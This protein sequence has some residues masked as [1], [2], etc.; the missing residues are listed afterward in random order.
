MSNYH[1]PPP[2]DKDPHLWQIAQRRASF[3]SHLAT[4]V[5]VITGLWIIWYFS[6]GRTYGNG[7]P[8]PVWPMAGWGIGIVF[9]Y[10]GAYVNTG[11]GSVENEYD[12][13]TKNQK[14]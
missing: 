9:H 10:L 1:Q 14:Q 11:F 8:W 6:G 4:Y 5:V 12:K 7:F 3:K 13:L 2:P